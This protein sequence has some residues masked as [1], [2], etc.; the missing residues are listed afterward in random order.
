[1][2]LRFVYIKRVPGMGSREGF[3]QAAAELA[4]DPLCDPAVEAQ[5]NSLR[6]WF[7]EHLELP[8]HFSRKKANGDG[9]DC[10]KG[11]SWFRPNAKD[12]ISKAFELKT[13]LDA[14]GYFIEVLRE[15]RIG[16]VIYEDAHQVV[17][18]PFSETTK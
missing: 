9:P 6:I 7:A 17:A 3:F 13:I 4:D 8:D 2:Y 1:M 15:R 16:Y 11:L 14:N 18:E 5:V 10:T 12:H